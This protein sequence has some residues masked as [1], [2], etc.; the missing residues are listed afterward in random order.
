MTLGQWLNSL[1]A[2]DHIILILLYSGSV[3][4]SKI[5][6]ETMID[7]YNEKKQYNKF[8]VQFRITPAALLTLGFIYSFFIYKILDA[9]FEF[10]P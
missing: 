7:Y 8:R 10:M 4:L 9:I 6:L 5:T 3:Y 2:M 1:S